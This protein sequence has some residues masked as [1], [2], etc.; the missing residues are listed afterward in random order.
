MSKKNHYATK[1]IVGGHSA[2]AAVHSTVCLSS[3]ADRAFSAAPAVASPIL[4]A[5]SDRAAHVEEEQSYEWGYSGHSPLPVTRG[6]ALPIE[7]A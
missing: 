3:D 1:A 7:N 2:T 6:K 4:E 5:D